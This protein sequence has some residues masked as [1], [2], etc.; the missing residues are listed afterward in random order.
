MGTHLT[1]HS[2]LTGVNSSVKLPSSQ[3]PTQALSTPRED[4]IL[5]ARPIVLSSSDLSIWR[6]QLG[7]PSRRRPFAM[8]QLPRLGL[9]SPISLILT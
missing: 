4:E 5:K 1:L 3:W 8:C 2:V 6:P 9:T 7:V